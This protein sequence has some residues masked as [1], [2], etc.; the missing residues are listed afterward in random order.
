MMASVVQQETEGGDG[1]SVGHAVPV[2][3]HHRDPVVLLVDFVYERRQDIAARVTAV[4]VQHLPYDSAR[5]GRTRRIDSSR[6]AK[7]HT[8]LLSS[9]SIV[10]QATATPPRESSSRH[11][12]ASVLLPNPEGAWM[13][14]SRRRP[15]ARSTSMTRPRATSDPVATGGRYFV[16]GVGGVVV[17]S[18]RT[19][20]DS[21]DLRRS[22]PR[23]TGRAISSTATPLWR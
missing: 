5:A 19:G 4:L 6:C 15:P 17:E 12:A 23:S 11:C 18:E 1:S 22:T 16:A 8:S 2:V 13:K 14:T 7:N 20:L 21:G 3:D 10:S 9:S